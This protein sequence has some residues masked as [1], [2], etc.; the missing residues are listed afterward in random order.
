MW[1]R[2]WLRRWDAWGPWPGNGGLWHERVCHGI[3][4]GWCVDRGADHRLALQH[5]G[6]LPADAFKLMGVSGAYW[7]GDVSRPQLQRISAGALGEAVPLPPPARVVSTLRP[8][9][10]SRPLG[11]SFRSPPTW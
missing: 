5:L 11:S 4:S 10:V 7:F 3:R 2:L 8:G 6:Q 1:V 9:D